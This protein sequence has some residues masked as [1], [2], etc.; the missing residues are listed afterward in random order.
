MKENEREKN[1]EKQKPIWK[2]VLRNIRPIF[3][4]FFCQFLVGGKMQKEF[5]SACSSARFEKYLF[6]NYFHAFSNLQTIFLLS[7]FKERQRIFF[8]WKQKTF[9]KFWN[10][11]LKI[12]TDWKVEI[13]K[14]SPNPH[15]NWQFKKKF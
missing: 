10:T 12:K 11:R 3:I 4:L 15:Q 1:N 14:N 9:Q 5:F 13:K 8:L 6:S 7:P 2:K